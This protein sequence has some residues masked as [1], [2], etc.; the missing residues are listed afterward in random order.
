MIASAP[1]GR[2]E[3]S[4]PRLSPN[5]ESGSHEEGRSKRPR[6]R[7]DRRDR[8]RPAGHR[9]AGKKNKKTFVVCK[10]GCKY[11]TLT[12]AVKKVKK[13]N[14]TI[15]VKPGTYKEGVIFEG[16]KYDGLTITGT[17]SDPHK[18]VFDGKN[19]KGPDGPR[20]ERDRGHRRQGRHVKN[21]TAQNFNSNG[22]FFHDSDAADGDK[23]LDCADYLVKNT[24]TAYNRAYNVF[25]FGCVGGRMTQNESTGTGDSAFY[26]G[27]HA[28]AEEPE[29]DGARP[30][31]RLRQQPGVLGDEL[32]LHRHP[33]QRLLQQRHRAD[34]EHA[35]LRAVSSRP[36]AA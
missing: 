7:R 31:H 32:P 34:A 3:R 11:P 2:F 35:R 13:K 20:A 21:L 9:V 27:A 36:T 23:T 26:V 14:S 8:C 25:A 15:K 24:Y 4:A 29:D 22:I 30:Q 17:K 19:A 16:H 12:K 5:E 33:P 18:T 1:P 28:A 10:H 6:R